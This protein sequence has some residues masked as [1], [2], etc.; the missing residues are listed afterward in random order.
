MG[1]LLSQFLGAEPG[2]G[3]AMYLALSGGEAKRSVLTAAATEAL[4]G[5]P[6]DLNL[7]TLVDLAT[8][9]IRKRRNDFAHGIWGTCEEL[10][11]A[12]LW[13]KANEALLLE[14]RIFETAKKQ[15]VLPL[16]DLYRRYY[17]SVLV[18]RLSELEESANQALEAQWS[19][20]YL[21]NALSFDEDTRV[22]A[23]TKLYDLP[24]IAR[25]VAS[26]NHQSTP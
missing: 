4:G 15:A 10:P 11:D 16:L 21:M 19:I 24:L 8:R 3:M 17:E 26:R 7:F 9:P 2:V 5:N 1:R 20:I 22:E 23:R 18:Y 13:H 12:L 25:Q 14:R 6:D